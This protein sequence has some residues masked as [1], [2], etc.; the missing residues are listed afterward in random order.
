MK[1][2]EISSE[3]T[4]MVAVLFRVVDSQKVKENFAV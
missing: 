4:W 1:S 2:P 3:E